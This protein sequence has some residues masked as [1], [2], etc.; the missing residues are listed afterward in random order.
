MV[1]KPAIVSGS[2]VWLFQLSSP[3]ALEIPYIVFSCLPVACRP[4]YERLP[5]IARSTT[6][7]IQHYTGLIPQLTKTICLFKAWIKYGIAASSSSSGDS[8][9]G[10]GGSSSTSGRDTGGSRSQRPMLPS[11]I[12]ELVVLAGCNSLV[13]QHGSKHA[14]VEAVQQLGVLE[15]F[16]A[17]L[18][19]VQELASTASIG[20]TSAAVDSSRA[21]TFATDENFILTYA[22][23]VPF[24]CRAVAIQRHSESWGRGPWLIHPLEEEYNVFEG[25]R[26]LGLEEWVMLGKDAGRLEALVKSCSW[27]TLMKN[28]SLGR[29]LRAFQSR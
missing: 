15:L 2:I 25:V 16:L 23:P 9:G 5:V 19:V 1:W 3:L 29:A 17:A 7:F 21:V 26:G 12:C 4:P 10:G 24:G 18:S 14:G 6:A 11:Y 27:G 13:K 20:A 22:K 28:S 8:R